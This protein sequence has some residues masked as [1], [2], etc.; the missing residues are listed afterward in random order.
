ME[1]HVGEAEKEDDK[2]DV[3]ENRQ[4]CNELGHVPSNDVRIPQMPSLSPFFWCANT[5]ETVSELS[6][7]LLREHGEKY[8][9]DTARKTGE[10][11]AVD[12][13]DPCIRFEGKLSGHAGRRSVG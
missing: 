10:E 3:N 7:P 1:Q 4:G 5:I 8:C 12:S 11:E 2:G 9:N 13:H 6:N